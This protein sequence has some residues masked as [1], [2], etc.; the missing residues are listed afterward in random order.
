M[1]LRL[2]A[3]VGVHAG[4]VDF[5]IESVNLGHLDDDDNPADTSASDQWLHTLGFRIAYPSEY[6]QPF[7]AYIMP[8]DDDLRG[9]LHMLSMGVTGKF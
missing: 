8:L 9:D 4:P 2:N 3:G 6:V 7:F 5:T 1:Y